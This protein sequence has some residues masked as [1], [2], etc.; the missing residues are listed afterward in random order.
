[1]AGDAAVEETKVDAAVE[2]TKDDAAVKETKV[3]AT[4]EEVVVAEVP[5]KEAII[6]NGAKSQGKEVPETISTEENGVSPLEENV[7][8]QIEYYF[9]KNPYLLNCSVRIIMCSFILE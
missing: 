1:M 8:R 9:G 6:E 3:E 5:E 4:K 2:E 7:I